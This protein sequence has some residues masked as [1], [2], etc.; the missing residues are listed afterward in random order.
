MT[1]KYQYFR[2][3]G[4]INGNISDITEILEERGHVG[5]SI[6]GREN[7]ETQGRSRGQYQRMGLG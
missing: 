2:Y 1:Q 7:D 4:K 3:G 6:C 5:F